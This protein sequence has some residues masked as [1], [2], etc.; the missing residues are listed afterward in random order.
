M[1]NLNWYVIRAVSGQEKKIKTYLENEI[2]RQGIQESI[3]EI[4]IPTEKIVE[5]RNGKK[6]IRE[7]N[8]F[9]GY[10]IISADLSKG[11]AYHLITT[12]PGVLGFLGN[13]TGN[14]K[15][16]VPLRQAEINRI[17]GK[18][19]DAV[20]EVEAPKVSFM[21]G[22]SVKII[23][24]PFSG[25]IGTVEEIFDDKKKLNVVVKIFGRSTPVELS[26]AQVEK[27]S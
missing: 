21:K 23:D 14:S 9:P 15:V 12:M 16:P 5:M 22:E 13:T 25:F 27:E 24:G 2:T 10:I 3:P 8:F 1:S 4:L 6:R 26:Y 18:V 7:K 20:E 11:D 17:L 19:E